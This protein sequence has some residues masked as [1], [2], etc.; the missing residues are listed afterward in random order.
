MRLIPP[1]AALQA[2]V[3]TTTQAEQSGWTSHALRHAVSTG[4]LIRVRPGVYAQPLQST[5]APD[6][7]LASLRHRAAAVSLT[8]RRVSLSHAAA[9]SL[10]GMEL[11][12][13][14]EHVCVT[15]LRGHRG[16][17]PGVHRH[18]ARLFPGHV[19]GRHGLVLTSAARTVLDI[20]REHGS[21]AGVVAADS[22]VR[23]GSTSREKL[24]TALECA[25]GWPGGAAAEHAIVNLDAASESAL[26][27]VSRLRIVGSGLPPP[28]TQVVL[29]SV[30]G[31]FLGRIDF[32]W[33]DAG[34]VG[35]ADG[36]AKYRST[37]D[38]REEKLRQE[39]LEAAG[40]IVIRWGWADL[41]A[42]DGTAARLRQ[43][44]A[45]GTAP[46]R[47]PRRWFAGKDPAWPQMSAVR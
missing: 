5:S 27:S 36:M 23:C 46:G 6:A 35:E 12:T 39:R 8:N 20:A 3:F 22:A 24:L 21:D 32:Y 17:M 33:D 40:L 43:A 29:R 42:F 13:V 47:A 25:N 31:M 2:G 18:R 28:R 38:L 14:P 10:H 15:F 9:G 37:D 11:L 19:V 7:A 26:E 44:I 4:E 34:V 41:R 1:R 16:S 45:R 30:G